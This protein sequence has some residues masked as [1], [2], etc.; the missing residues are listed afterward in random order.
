MN[1]YCYRVFAILA[2]VLLPSSILAQ[3]QPTKRALVVGINTYKGDPRKPA[4]RIEK[5]LVPRLPVQGETV[6]R[7]F[8]NL[9]GPVNDATDFADLLV[10]DFG[11]PRENVRLLLEE[12]AT[13]QNILDT[14]ERDLVKDKEDNSGSVCANDVE[15]FFYSGHGS[16]IRNRYITDESSPE[17]F[18]Q[19]LV[20]YDAV[21][22]VPDIRS[23]ELDK[24][25]LKV[26]R[27]GVIL[28]VI[29]DSC[30]SGGLSRGAVQLATGKSLKADGRYVNDPG[31]RDA[32]KKAILP[33]KL[34]EPGAH[35]VLLLAAAFETEEAEEPTQAPEGEHLH[36]AL[37]DALLKKLRDHGSHESIGTIFDD[38]KFEVGLRFANQHPQIFGDGRLNSDLFGGPA[39]STTGMVVRVK[40][41]LDDG[42]VK[43]DKG[44]LAGL[45]PGSE[46]VSV[47]GAPGM[48]LVIREK[49]TGATE[50][51]AEVKE[52]SFS[53]K[54]EGSTFRLDK[55][56]VPE[57]NSL[58]VYYAKDGPPAE[59]LARDAEVL[60][61]LESS[62]VKMVS[63]PTAPPPK[64]AGAMRQIWWL[65][66]SWRMMPTRSTAS[67]N[68][69]KSLDAQK[70]RQALGGSGRLWVNFPMPADQAA[71]L[72][73]GEGNND[74][75]RVQTQPGSPRQEQYVLAGQWTGKDL[76]YAWI[77]PGITDD[78][79]G[80]TNLPVR[81]DWIPSADTDSVSK[82][83]SKALTL[84]R[85]YGW[86]TLD[87]P[88]GG[89]G[90]GVFPYRLTLRKV[91]TNRS[92]EPGKDKTTEDEQY[93]IWLTADQP[94]VTALA[95]TGFIM[96]RWVYVLAIDRD[97]NTA[98]IIPAGPSNVGN[99]V[100][101]DEIP[102]AEIQMTSDPYDFS[103][104]APFGLD[105]YILLTTSDPL[106]PRILNAE[107]VRTRS[108]SR[109]AGDP[110][111]NLIENIGAS[112]LSRGSKVPVPANWSIQRVT[113]RSY[114]KAK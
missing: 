79:Q 7:G 112:S 104:S 8:G 47:S 114:P 17:K 53:G 105:T 65:N 13:A 72:G 21:D 106:D 42:A 67:Q 3:C 59:S 43:L 108:E 98:A 62:G 88:G 9:R 101:G 14:F 57:Q 19:T 54:P 77:R 29:A 84:N 49:D 6:D 10:S 30:Q 91:G 22:G 63:D 82:L 70:V 1:P 51:V 80:N 55:W 58:T 5:P 96:K 110:L 4:F 89:S 31:P 16:Q 90:A 40:Q 87:L 2:A 18:D 78:D 32:N 75:V 94:E 64:G 28:T 107:G 24:L 99:H 93:K 27:K 103:I 85:I 100:P 71:K 69:G 37:T 48:R 73:L 11:F 38:V 20:P 109:G 56:V 46:L 44:T 15:V 86:M 41:K 36:G 35:A 25:Y 26:A 66:G 81:T 33:T 61:A 111:A 68:L 50:S 39:N 97:G 12:N 83:R 113:F 92:L 45:Y 95:R 76:Q 74:A 60:S 23:K 52:G 102:S 34:S